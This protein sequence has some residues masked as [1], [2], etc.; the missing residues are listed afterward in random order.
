MV[1][2][3]LGSCCLGQTS[4]NAATEKSTSPAPTFSIEVAPPVGPIRLGVP[5]NVIVTVTNISDKDIYWVADFGKDTIYKAF[6]FLLV[7][8]GRE[9]ETT[10]FHRKI[11]GRTRADDPLEVEHSNLMP[12]PHPPG[13]MFTMTI[14]LTRLYKITE[15]GLYTLDVS[16]IDD[17]SKTTVRSKTLTLKVVP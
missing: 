13:K 2:L 11:T 7:K 16:R 9:V 10:F 12:F 6:A 4:P 1:V 3:L 15:P 17:D 8:D 14:D 5:L